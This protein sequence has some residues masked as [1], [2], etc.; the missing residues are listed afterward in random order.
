MKRKIIA[1]SLFLA[2]CMQSPSYA[3]INMGNGIS[4]REFNKDRTVYYVEIPDDEIPDIVIDGYELLNK[5]TTPAEKDSKV[6]KENVTVLKNTE[7]GIRYRFI[8][9][10][11]EKSKV[12]VKGAT[13]STDGKLKIEGDVAGEDIFKVII[14]KPE[15]KYSEKSIRWEDL[16]EGEQEKGVLD[17]I[18]VKSGDI[19][20]GVILEYAFPKSAYSGNYGILITGDNL[21][22]NYYNDSVFYMSE[23]DL[24][25]SLKGFSEICKK[26]A[27]DE[28]IDELVNYIIKNE[29]NL[30]LELAYFNQ[31]SETGK[32]RT[33]KLLF[34]ED[35]YGDVDSVRKELNKAII[36]SWGQEG[37]SVSGILDEYSDC[38]SLA[39]LEEYRELKTKTLVD[40][41]VKYAE[42]EESFVG[43]FNMAVAISMINES[44]PEAV[45][46]VMEYTK[47]YLSISQDVYEAFLDNKDICIRALCNKNFKTVDEIEKA[48]KERIENK[49]DKPSTNKK[50]SSGGGGG[51]GYT[52]PSITPVPEPKE[53]IVTGNT[54]PFDDLENYGWAENAIRHMYI[55]KIISGKSENKFAPADKVKREEFVK[56]IVN[57][58]ELT[59]TAEITFEDV[60]DEWFREYIER[61]FAGGII[62]GLNGQ[63][64][65]VGENITREDMAVIIYRAVTETGLELDIEISEKAEL[66]DLAEVSDYAK[67]AVEFLISKGAIN[68]SEGKFKPKEFASRAEAAQMIYNVIKIR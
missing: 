19:K 49:E 61:G 42:D 21:Q 43:K 50:P 33:A 26:E 45:A 67:E 10:K 9:E 16:K 51:G 54:L 62:T 63:K 36:I 5:A 47:E 35:G 66:S 58:F 18:E 22:E 27:N 6:V 57:S 2:I 30:Y 32:K 7:T 48:I 56:I 64:F 34:T 11:N 28:N 17:I 40:E 8:F 24:I 41:Y 55:N 68:G 20:D 15:E 31:L 52:V 37:K 38:L 14:L 59:E 53:E 3:D 65:G 23:Q 44:E 1:F 60:G 4:D 12:S 29:K 46:E 25:D 39:L 13:L